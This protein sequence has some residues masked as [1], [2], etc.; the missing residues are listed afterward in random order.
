M[1]TNIH[2]C[3][4]IETHT[5]F[6]VSGQKK[7]TYKMKYWATK[8]RIHKPTHTHTFFSLFWIPSRRPAKR[9][10][11][12]AGKGAEP[13]AVP[14]LVVKMLM[15]KASGSS[16]HLLYC[17]GQDEQVTLKLQKPPDAVSMSDKLGQKAVTSCRPHPSPDKG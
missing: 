16:G 3:T 11:C 4:P 17:D 13:R 6:R 2:S 10:G 12:H 5:H 7:G 15:L 8:V 1:C 14:N 9:T